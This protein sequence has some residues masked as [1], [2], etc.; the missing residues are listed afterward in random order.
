MFGKRFSRALAVT[1]VASLVMATAAFA[2]TAGVD[3]DA[4]AANN[5]GTLALGDVCT[6]G[7]ASAVVPVFGVRNGNYPNPQVW[8]NGATVSFSVLGTPSAGLSGSFLSGNLV[9]LPDDWDD[10]GNNFESD[11]VD[12]TVQFTAGAATGAFAG[13]ISFRGTGAGSSG[14][15]TN[16]DVTLSVTANAVTCESPNSAPVITSATFGNNG[17]NGCRVSSTLSVVFTD[18]DASDTHTASVNWGDGSAEENLGTVAKSFAASHTYNA[19][20]TYT[21]TVSVSDGTDSDSETANV[22]VLQTYTTAFLA[23]LDGS[24]PSRLIANTMKKGRVVPVKVTIYDDCAQT[25]VNDPATNVTIDV[26]T[27]SFTAN[28]TDSVETFSDAG[29]SSN[30]STSFRFNA[31]SS[32]ASGGFWIYNLDTNGFTI[33]SHSY[34]VAPK[35]GSVLANSTYAILKPTK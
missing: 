12:A 10:S 4:T 24:N 14:S 7:T 13:T 28:S 11:A 32:I 33:G 30:L 35:V 20:A 21:A 31:D 9:V 34:L 25:W 27:A 23:P 18:D 6:D 19:P 22:I 15:A 3:G 26:K 1:T 5:Q 8:A 29:A 2:D 16:R 17:T